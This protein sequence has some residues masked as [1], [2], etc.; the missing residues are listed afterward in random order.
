MRLLCR[1]QWIIHPGDAQD[2]NSR[3]AYCQWCSRLSLKLN[4]VIAV[5]E[6]TLLPRPSNVGKPQ[7]SE[8]FRLASDG[9]T[10]AVIVGDC[11][12]S[13]GPKSNS[14]MSDARRLA[15]CVLFAFTHVKCNLSELI[16]PRARWRL[17]TTWTNSEPLQHLELDVGWSCLIYSNRAAAMRFF[18]HLLELA[19][20]A[21]K[22]RFFI[23][24]G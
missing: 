5:R 8:S 4:S 24:P 2:N 19:G 15:G 7:L 14:N 22:S 9:T 16:R 18:W 6:C 3:Q 13:T 21:E 20:I 1:T 12:K 10:R 17:Q 11:Y 23:A